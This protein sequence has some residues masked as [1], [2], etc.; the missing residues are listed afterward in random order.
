MKK[1]SRI[2]QE[3]KNLFRAAVG[4]AKPLKSQNRVFHF[5]NSQTVRT[6]RHSWKEHRD[7]HYGVSDFVDPNNY[8]SNNQQLSFKIT[9]VQNKQFQK[10]KHGQILIEDILDLHGLTVEQARRRVDL[11]INDCRESGLRCVL[12][13]HGKG[14]PGKPPILKTMVNHWLKQISDVIAFVSAQPGDGGTGALYVLLKNPAKHLAE[15]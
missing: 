10:L 13:V 4:D 3:D 15:K 1:K 14:K 2:A 6:M 8:C 12:I 7:E 5:P 11:F 9:G